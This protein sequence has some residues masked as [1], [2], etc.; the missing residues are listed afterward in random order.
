MPVGRGAGDAGEEADVFGRRGKGRRGLRPEPTE[1]WPLDRV[2]VGVATLRTLRELIRQ[3]AED[4]GRP[5]RAW[6]LA[7]RSGVSAQGSANSLERLSEAGLVTELT[8]TRPGRAPAYRLHR[9]HPVVASMARLFEAE[10]SMVAGRPT[11]RDRFEGL[12]DGR[13]VATERGRGG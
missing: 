8:P 13:A 1:G 6:D 11:W 7:L 12:R 2:L 3:D 4:G 5:P 10:R 9:T